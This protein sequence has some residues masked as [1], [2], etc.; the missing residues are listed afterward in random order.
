MALLQK[1]KH[2]ANPSCDPNTKPTVLSKD[3]RIREKGQERRICG[4][5]AQDSPGKL[6]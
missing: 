3:L 5:C 6:F 4:S 1:H 2:A